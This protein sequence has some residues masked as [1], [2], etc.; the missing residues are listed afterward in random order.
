LSKEHSK[1]VMD[2]LNK[3]LKRYHFPAKDFDVELI[4][5]Q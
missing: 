1:Y 4:E 3:A 5:K 2:E